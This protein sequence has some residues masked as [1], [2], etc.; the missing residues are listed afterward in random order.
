MKKER[1]VSQMTCAIL[2][3]EI[4]TADDITLGK[5]RDRFKKYMDKNKKVI[6]RNRVL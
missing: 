4:S 5:I 1:N 6:K 3:D 2:L